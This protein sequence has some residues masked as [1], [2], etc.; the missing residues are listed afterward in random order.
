MRRLLLLPDAAARALGALAVAVALAF[1]VVTRT[2]VGRD[3]LRRSLEAAFARQFHGTL[4]IGRLSGNVVGTLDAA[5]VTIRDASG[6][7]VLSARRV[8]AR[9][10]LRGL[11]GRSFR[12]RSLTFEAP[13]VH[14]VQADDG[15]WNV[16]RLFARDRPPGPAGPAWRLGAPRVTVSD[17]RI[18]V[19]SAAPAPALISQGRVFDVR[20]T[21]VERIAGT[22]RVEWAG[23][24]RSVD[25][26]GLTFT[27]PEAAFRVESLAGRYA[28]RDSTRRLDGVRL[29]AGRTR[30]RLD[31]LLP[32]PAPGDSTSA[33]PAR[34]ALDGRADF[35]AL[36]R[37]VPALPLAGE[38][39]LT[40]A[41][42]GTTADVTVE[43]A[44]I[45]AGASR[46]EGAGR[47]RV[48]ADSTWVDALAL[49]AFVRGDDAARLVPA[50]PDRV[51]ALLGP[52]TT[53]RWTG[54]AAVPRDTPGRLRLAGTAEVAQADARVAGALRLALAGVA[55]RWA[56]D[57][58]VRNVDVRR[59]ALRPSLAPTVLTGRLAGEGVGVPRLDGTGEGRLAARVRL[60]RSVVLGRSF[61]S[62]RVDGRLVRGDLDAAGAL[63]QRGGSAR[64]RVAGAV[65]AARRSLTVQATL[66]RFD[67]GALLLAD[68]LATRL[69]G[70]LNVRFAGPT[71][72]AA[73]ADVRLA[74][75]TAAVRRGRFA[76]TLRA[77]RADLFLAPTGDDV[78]DAEADA[79]RV[80]LVGPLRAD[81]LRAV[82]GAVA[83]RLVAALARLVPGATVPAAPALPALAPWRLA[84]R[85]ELRDRAALAALIPALR[86]VAGLRAT[87]SAAGD[88]AGVR[89]TVQASADTFRAGP[90]TRLAGFRADVA[91][92]DAG[93]AAP[94]LTASLT[95]DSLA[96]GALRLG[97]PVLDG[98]LDPDGS[99]RVSLA[100][101]RGADTLA[102]DAD[103]AALPG[104]TRV[105]LT[106][107]AV[108][109]GPYRLATP[110]PQ[111]LDVLRADTT[112]ARG[113]G[114]GPP[115]AVSVP[116]L[117]L[118]AEGPERT[119]GTFRL[120]GR[121]SARAADT[122]HVTADAVDLAPVLRNVPTKAPIAGTVT[123][124][125]ALASAF[126]QPTLT[127]TVVADS[128][129]WGPNAVG[130]LTAR[131]FLR[132]GDEAV[133]LDAQLTP[134]GPIP[135]AATRDNRV[136]LTGTFRLPRADRPGDAGALAL[137]V[138][139]ARAEVFFLDYFFPTSLV[140]TSGVVDGNVRIGG[141]LR[142][143][144][145]DGRLETGGVRLNLPRF[146]LTY[147]AVGAARL[148]PDG[149][150]SENLV[151]RDPTGGTAA[152]EGGIRFNR[153]R[154]F[155][156]DVRARLREFQLLNVPDSDE[157][158]FYGTLW[159]SGSA[160]LTGPVSAA[161]LRS[162][163]A[164]ASARSVVSI[165]LREAVTATD[166][167]FVVFADSA[168]RLPDLATFDRRTSVLRR[169]LAERSFTE[170]LSMDL[171]L[172]VPSGS[173]VRLVVDPLRGDVMTARVRGQ[174]EIDLVDGVFETYGPLDVEGGDYPFT[175]GDLFTR[176]F[177]I[178]GGTITF[179]G[180]PINPLLDV[181]ASY[182]T[183]AS[184]RGLP[185]TVA[186][187]ATAIPVVVRL[188][189]TERVQT[190]QVALTLVLDRTD[191]AAT[192]VASTVLETALNEPERQTEYATS[193]LL[194]N[195]F[196][197]TT[198]VAG[199]TESLQS[200]GNDLAFAS[201]SQL[202]TAQLN[203]YLSAVLP[204]VEFNVGL[205]RTATQDL[206]LTYGVA[207]RL[208]DERLVIRGEGV[209]A[210]TDAQQTR[211]GGLQGELV[212][213]VRLS[214]SVSVEVFLRREDDVLERVTTNTTGAAISY[215][216]QFASW[217]GFW[218]RL[219]GRRRSAEPPA[220]PALATED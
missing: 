206:D 55:T 66:A 98:R 84:G 122:L 3:G 6:R 110:G 204:G 94:A 14:L 85:V 28:E 161:T 178:D 166:P 76:A 95:A 167:G 169:P 124:T 211:P 151:A 64:F 81:V 27:L 181:T 154:Y 153:F 102:A 115:V 59:L 33:R 114:A 97:A 13:Q 210:A 75:P 21:R 93:T 26:D 213:E 162:S 71:L 152:V 129:T 188:A 176:R 63:A 36:R 215:Q 108:S 173:T 175:A 10:T 42:A 157:L 90:R 72:D 62:L 186:R 79:G 40:L 120:R 168:G 74:L 171:D 48:G 15:S 30:L 141:T 1:V 140:G 160:D 118:V 159:A 150:F 19:E 17:G 34:L 216:T 68:S 107:L 112:G 132:P 121:L 190:P 25:V 45:A 158:A 58:D 105:T 185:E 155:S 18:V 24:E 8:V 137:D 69:D 78:F 11:F 172:R 88:S 16:A 49:T 148:T 143:P 35:D 177:R 134:T 218:E 197:L 61:D 44:R 104:R 60:G 123:G 20:N 149:L 100:A 205:Q 212:V 86:G 135:G 126:A 109:A 52:E 23:D 51:R 111:T 103:L 82:S 156:F 117:V 4:T 203:R 39:A 201:V 195:S 65:P 180:D 9:P 208:L 113:L 165:P 174:L 220:D 57:L 29:T 200:S 116:G 70:A 179:D 89:A 193:V 142:A 131:S 170:G 91:L 194:T 106:R 83:P 217:R 80:R 138:A 37:L 5:D 164:V 12:L 125:L 96:A 192:T 53:L 77:V 41:A 198:Q 43:T 101:R 73:T 47:V 146:G 22:F 183:R 145:F 184:T 67:A 136:A 31:A 56:A 2:D 207:L 199:S 189:L 196:L 187:D 182:R 127:G 163:D 139:V 214:Q 209:V 191:R 219:F 87:F 99:G 92:A 50:L 54:D 32:R 130:R 46:A 128:L 144:T 119:G 38:A 202:V 133:S 147:A 7:P